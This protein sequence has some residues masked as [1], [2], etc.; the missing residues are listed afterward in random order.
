MNEICFVQSWDK[1]TA[2][3]TR[4]GEFLIRNPS[5][6]LTRELDPDLFWQIHRGT[7]VNVGCIDKVSRSLYGRLVLKLKEIPETLIVSRS[8]AQLFKQM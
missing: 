7:I 8:Y 2:V 1:Y 4:E 3:I 5:R 6:T